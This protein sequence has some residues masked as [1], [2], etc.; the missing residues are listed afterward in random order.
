MGSGNIHV[1]LPLLHPGMEEVDFVGSFG[2]GNRGYCNRQCC[3][4]EEDTKAEG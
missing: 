3:P 2:S 1:L 4:G